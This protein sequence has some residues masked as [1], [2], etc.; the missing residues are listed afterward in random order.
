MRGNEISQAVDF[1]NA[2]AARPAS[3]M[4]DRRDFRWLRDPALQGYGIGKGGTGEDDYILT[5]HLHRLPSRAEIKVPGRIRIPGLSDPV[6]THVLS[7][8]APAHCLGPMTCAAQIA[9]SDAVDEVGSLGCL[10]KS[11]DPADKN[12][13]LLSNA[14]VLAFSGP[15]VPMINKDA[16][17]Y[18]PG[19]GGAEAAIAVLAAWLP[20][21]PGDGYPNVVDAAIA[22][23]HDAASFSP[24][25]PGIGIPRGIV[26]NPSKDMPVRMRG[27]VSGAITEGV[28]NEVN[29]S[30][31]LY[32]PQPNGK[33]DDFGWSGAIRTSPLAI[34]GDSGSIVLD[35]NNRIVG[36]LYAGGQNVDS[37]LTP[38]T[39][40]FNKLGLKL[41]DDPSEDQMAEANT[42][43]PL[44]FKPPVEHRFKATPVL[45][46][47][48][49]GEARGQ[50]RQGKIA[51]GAVV[52]NRAH[53]QKSNWGL[54]VEEVC[55]KPAQFSCW[56]EGDPNRAKMLALDPSDPVFFECMGIARQVLD[57]A[58][59]DPT[60][61]ANHYVNL[62][63]VL[64]DWAIPSKQT[65][66]IGAHTFYKL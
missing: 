62:G 44:G 6:E 11:T 55:Q 24:V 48:I 10:V 16:I 60:G 15:G 41:P 7:A 31:R 25:I 47:T 1:L 65:A 57:G 33:S 35:M 22:R 3:A 21:T 38:I 19:D 51:V 17:V 37:I 59:L 61:G 46:R 66:V 23:I 54:T 63:V 36:L 43:L 13:Y 9:R 20:F 64:P 45:A 32:C 49:W 53:A 2:C 14:H 56:N 50:S 5:V 12:T 42:T 26:A 40:V 39:A 29:Y 18:P 58:I 4:A 34:A 52:A 28:I 30:H 8:P 27:A